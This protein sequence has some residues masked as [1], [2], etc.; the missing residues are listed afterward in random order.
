MRSVADGLPCPI[1]SPHEEL[2]QHGDIFR[3]INGLE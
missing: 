2:L 1:Q 3:L